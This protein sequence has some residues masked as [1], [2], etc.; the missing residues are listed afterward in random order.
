M[1]PSFWKKTLDS[2]KNTVRGTPESRY[3]KVVEK[4]LEKNRG[5]I[6]SL[7]D[8]DEGKKD[9]STAEVERRLHDIQAAV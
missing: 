3:L 9:I 2:I 1:S 5:V 4:Q 8:Y 6:E 7:R